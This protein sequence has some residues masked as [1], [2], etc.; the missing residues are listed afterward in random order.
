MVR[1]TLRNTPRPSSTART[2]E[3]KSSPPST[4]SAAFLVTSVPDPIATPMSAAFTE[5]ASLTPSPVMATTSPA[6]CSAFTMVSLCPGLTRANTRKRLACAGKRSPIASS[7]SPVSTSSRVRAMPSS[8]AMASAVPGPSPVIIT[9]RTPARRHSSTASFAPSRGGSRRAAKP[10]KS[11]S[12]SFFPSANASTRIAL[13]AYAS[14]SARIRA[15]SAS[16]SG[17]PPAV[18]QEARTTSG[19][20]FL[21][22]SA[23]SSAATRTLMQRASE[24]NGLPPGSRRASPRSPRASAYSTSATSVGSPT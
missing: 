19:A 2:M 3:E 8:L 14:A 22:Y 18:R 9:V 23:P 11:R 13:P 15:R 1:R 16:S 5:G 10:R 21:R 7:S 12:V 24:V 17:L 20:P 4:M 6:P